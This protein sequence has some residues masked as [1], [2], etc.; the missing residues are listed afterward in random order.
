MEEVEVGVGVEKEQKVGAEEIEMG[1][2]DKVVDKKEE[3]VEMV[4]WGRRRNKSGGE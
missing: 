2:E 3:E 1:E 4:G